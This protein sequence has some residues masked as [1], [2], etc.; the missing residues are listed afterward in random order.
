MKTIITEKPSVA[1]DIAKVLKVTERKDGYFEGNGYFISWAFGHLVHLA[2]P[3]SYDEKFKSWRMSDLPIIPDNFIKEL[4]KDDSIKKQFNTIKSLLNNDKV[5]EVICATDAGREGE[6]I[7]RFI[8]ERAECKKPIARL[9]ISSQTDKAISDGFSALKTGEEYQP[10]YDSAISRTEADWL[11]GMNATRAYT[12][13]YSRGNG[14]MS[15]G[16]VQTP[17][18][19][20]IVDRYLE[21]TNFVPKTYFEIFTNIEHEKGTFRGKWFSG[22]DERFSDKDLATAVY[23]D[24]KSAPQGNIDKITSKEKK[25]KQPLLY[26]L[27][28]LQKDA[29]KRFKFS[30][31]QTLQTMQALYERHKVLTYPRTSSRYLSKDMVPQLGGLMKNLTEIDEYAEI[32]KKIV[33]KGIKTNKRIVDDTKVTDHHA[34]IP[35]D[36]KATLK[37]LTADELKIFDLVIKRFL[38]VFLDECKKH[39]T[40]IVT[41]FGAN[42]FK[43]S[44]IIIKEQGWREVYLKDTDIKDDES[45]K[46]LP[47]VAKGDTV[48]QKDLKL[49]EKQT[50]PPALYNEASILAAMETA[51]KYIEDEEARQAMKDCGLGTASTRAQILERLIKVQYITR[52]KSRLIPTEKGC[53]LISYIQD[54]ELMSAELTG[55]WEKKLN[56]MAQNKYSRENYMDEIKDFT[57]T[58][59][60]NVQEQEGD[61]SNSN[62]NFKVIGKCPACEGDVIETTKAYSCSNWKERGCKFVIW[63]VIAGKEVTIANAKKLLIDGKTDLIKGFKSKAGSDFDAS[64]VMVE[65]QVKFSFDNPADSEILGKCK[66][67]DGNI[68]ETPKAY[69]CSNWRDKGCKFAIWKEIA[70]K[71]ISL[72]IAKTIIKDGKSGKLDG[73]K[74]KAGSAFQTTLVMN[75]EGR[76]EFDFS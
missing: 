8:Y 49:E 2:Y 55:E 16:R 68:I 37:N 36:K 53:Q 51:G 73:F 19:K 24:I 60:K 34:I 47:D 56:N 70:G 76:I 66:L 31:D 72:D 22:K 41:T 40:D 9:W 4:Q 20:M 5:T 28:E 3:E 65:N 71:K 30:A 61:A 15:V 7:F 6:L 45:D 42:K 1:R 64:L 54:K 17:I 21:N 58:I 52:E 14:V 39:Q 10:L 69:S 48:N 63:K 75:K 74:S 18:L 33:D 25:E 11:I 29:N 67:C 38:S 57:K 35:T 50:K 62:S 44:G 23:E 46:K 26:D 13:R 32:S 43:T 27:T 59:V 12:I